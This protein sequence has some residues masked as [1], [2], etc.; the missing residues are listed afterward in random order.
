MDEDY[1]G[2]HIQSVPRHL[3]PDSNRWTAHVLINWTVCSREQFR[4]FDVKRGFAT[5]ED[6]ELIGLIRKEVDR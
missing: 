2:Y 1:K 6:V 5:R 4:D 3:L